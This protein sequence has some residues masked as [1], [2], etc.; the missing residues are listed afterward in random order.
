MERRRFLQ[1]TAIG[2]TAGMAGQLAS[3]DPAEGEV[4]QVKRFLSV[5]ENGYFAFDDGEP[6]LP[7]G[8]FYGNFVHRVEEGQVLEDRIGSIRDSSEAEK[9]AWFQLLAEN[10]VNCLRI[11]SRDHNKRGVD[12]WDKVGALNEPLLETWEQYWDVALEYGIRILPTIHESFYATYAPYRNPETMSAMVVPLYGE[13]EIAKLPDYRR[14]LLEGKPI[15]AQGTYADP[16]MIRARNDYVD[17]LIPR[18]REHPSILLYE[19]ENE[20]EIGIYDWTNRNIAWIREHDAK[21]P[22]CISHSGAGLMTADPIPHSRR[23]GIDF[24]SYHIYPVDRVCQ[25]EFDYGMAV[26]MLAR[27]AM[28]GVPAGAGEAGSHILEGGPDG[29]WRYAIARD[30]AWMPFLSGNNHIMF[31]DAAHPEVVACKGVSEAA[32]LLE[33]AGFRRKRPGIAVDVSHPLDDDIH[34]RGEEGYAL[35]TNMG[36]YEN[37]FARLGVDFDYTF[38]GE[39][40]DTVL[41]GDRFEPHAPEARPFVLSAGYQMKSLSSASDDVLVA[42]I[43]NEGEN[44]HVGKDWFAGWVRKPV[45]A[46]FELDVTLPGTYEGFLHTFDDESR[47]DVRID[48][49]GRL[50]KPGPTDRDFWLYLRRV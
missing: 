13:G 30:T 8:G 10:G 38:G 9:R 23:T 25:P 36:R 46:R 34:F 44:V 11:M 1:T 21:T 3:A 40:Y 43:R 16:D 4:R 17:A 47:E 6:F 2:L 12:E 18:L 41:P 37:H 14:R 33:L 27:Y 20:Q 28:L 26:S 32:E 24:Y 29:R 50:A 49:Q 5:Q 48:G 19:L 22:V 45:P 31:W 15:D 42:Y 7:L 35:Y 39:G